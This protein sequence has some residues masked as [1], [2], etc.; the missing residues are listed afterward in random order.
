[1]KYIDG[2]KPQQMMSMVC[3]AAA[4]A[5]YTAP[6][7]SSPFTSGQNVACAGLYSVRWTNHGSVIVALRVQDN[8]S[9]VV[10]V[11]VAMSQAFAFGFSMSW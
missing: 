10:K 11:C 4:I 7:A 6:N 1:M 8:A 5:S 9:G 2:W 3:L